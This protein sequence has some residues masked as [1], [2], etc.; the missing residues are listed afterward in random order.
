MLVDSG[1]LAE[2]HRHCD[3]LFAEA[4]R[5][6]NAARW[7]ELGR[8]VNALR[9]AVLAHFRYEEQHIFPLYEQ[10]SGIEG[11]TEWLCAQHD[12]MRAMLWL[13]GAASPEQDAP[14]YAAQLAELQEAF[15]AHAA[16]EERRMY[17]VFEQLLKAN[18]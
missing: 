13:L 18:A 10:A 16:E 11:S 12:D 15:D 14:R 3:D 9:E 5:A 1:R 6:A 7:T 2:H 17:P 4:R 8:C